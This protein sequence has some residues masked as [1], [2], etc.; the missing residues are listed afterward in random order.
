MESW[1]TSVRIAWRMNAVAAPVRVF[2]QAI[3]SLPTKVALEVFVW[4]G[5]GLERKVWQRQISRRQEQRRPFNGDVRADI[6]P[7]LEPEL[8]NLTSS[9]TFQGPMYQKTALLSSQ[10]SGVHGWLRHP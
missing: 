10:N 2:A 9:K 4:T 3:R 5:T 8:F 7:I 1:L 6:R